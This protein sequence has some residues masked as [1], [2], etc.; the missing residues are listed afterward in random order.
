[1]RSHHKQVATAHC[2]DE[3]AVRISTDAGV[4]AQLAQP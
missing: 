4:C 3:I 1:M 2:R